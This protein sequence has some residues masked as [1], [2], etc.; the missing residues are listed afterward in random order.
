MAG[1]ERL[2]LEYDRAVSVFRDLT[3]IRFKLLALVP[4]LSGVAVGFLRTGES[5]VTLL[6]VGLLGLTATIGVLVYELR[7]SEIRLAA[8]RRIGGLEGELLGGPIVSARP[9]RGPRLFG[10]IGLDHSLGLALVYGAALAGWG[11]VVAW[12]ALAA[13]EVGHARDIGVV[14]G[15]VWGL[16]V[17]Q[18]VLR[19]DRPE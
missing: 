14:N 17:L 9:E 12:G 13:L 4:T 11:Y 10:G 15:A 16:L 1:D 6:A 19:L 3:D 8:A 2:R 18:Q 7:N 5:A